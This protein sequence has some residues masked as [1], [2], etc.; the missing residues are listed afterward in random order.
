VVDSPSQ[1]VRRG[2]GWWLLRHGRGVKRI[3]VSLPKG[4]L[5]KAS[6][7]SPPARSETSV[8]QSMPRWL[9]EVR[10]TAHQGSPAAS[11][12]EIFLLPAYS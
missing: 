11:P 9:G 2:R 10:S 1:R 5:S 8:A 6:F 4:W 12:S 3:R 7:V